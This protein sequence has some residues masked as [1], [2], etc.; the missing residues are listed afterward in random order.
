MSK[1]NPSPRSVT[2]TFTSVNVGSVLSTLVSGSITQV[3]PSFLFK[4]CQVI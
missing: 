4:Q 1:E 3:V 2:L